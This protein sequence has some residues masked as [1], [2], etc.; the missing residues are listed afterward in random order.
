MRRGDRTDI[1]RSIL[2]RIFARYFMIWKANGAAGRINGPGSVGKI[3]MKACN[4]SMELLF[5]GP[6]I[7]DPSEPLSS[8]LYFSCLSK[9]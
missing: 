3:I 4:F 5:M 2:D 8:A 7:S 6:R 1:C 9:H